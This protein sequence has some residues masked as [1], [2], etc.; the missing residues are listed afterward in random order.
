M[1]RMSC[2]GCSHCGAL[3]EDLQ[4]RLSLY[5]DDKFVYAP[6]VQDAENGA[7]YTLAV[8]NE[9]RDWETGIVDDWDL[10]FVK[11]NSRGTVKPL[12]LS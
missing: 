1:K 12:L 9:S 3:L 5:G 4:E 6:V 8:A 2:A 10:E 7:L 11:I